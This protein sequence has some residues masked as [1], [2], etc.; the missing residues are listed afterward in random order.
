MFQHIEKASNEYIDIKEDEIGTI[1]S[2]NPLQISVGGLPLTKDNIYINPTLLEHTMGFATLTG[3]IG[4][5]QTTISNG[6]ILFKS[7]LKEK[8]LVV[9]R[10]LK[11]G[12]YLVRCKVVGG[13]SI[14]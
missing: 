3:T 13:G 9:L 14:E 5:S 12:K 2:I 4:D 11:N 10:E 8:D 1:I 6:S 7:V